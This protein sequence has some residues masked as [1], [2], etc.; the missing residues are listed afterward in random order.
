MNTFN[1]VV[2]VILL[3]LLIPLVSFVLI[4]PHI[5]LVNVGTWLTDLGYTLGQVQPVLRI[6]GGIVLA[7]LFILIALAV[8]FFEVRPQRKKFIRVQQ[9]NGGLATVSVESVAQQLQYHLDPLPGVLQVKSKI[10]P[11]KEEVAVAVDVK[12][13]T[14]VN[15][16]EL[17]AQCVAVVRDVLTR[18]MGLQVSGEPQ[19]RIELASAAGKG[20]PKTGGPHAAGPA[21]VTPSPEPVPA[22]TSETSEEAGETFVADPWNE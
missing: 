2:I 21:P 11:H 13:G 22:P 10:K 5:A 20:A 19:V 3:L 15:V 14:G 18:E 17:A 6:L 16:P 12:V 8:I 4:I 9:V 7:L 1:R